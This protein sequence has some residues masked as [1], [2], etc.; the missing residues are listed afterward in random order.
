MVLKSKS[1]CK[2]C[3]KSGKTQDAGS[4]RSSRDK[5]EEAASK[6]KEVV[7]FVTAV[8]YSI[9]SFNFEV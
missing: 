1:F 9:S 3:L 5:R 7:F 2:T 8:F 6:D 4:T